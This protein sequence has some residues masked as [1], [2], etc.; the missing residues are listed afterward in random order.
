MDKYPTD[1]CECGFLLERL[2]AAH[3]AATEN[4]ELAA[5][6]QRIAESRTK[7]LLDLRNDLREFIWEHFPNEH[8]GIESIELIVKRIILRLIRERMGGRH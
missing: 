4:K 1:E 5:N 8:Y 2:E 6:W 3:R 7:A